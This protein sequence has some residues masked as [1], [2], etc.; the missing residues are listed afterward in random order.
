MRMRNRY[1]HKLILVAWVGTIG[2]DR[3]DRIRKI[4]PIQ[5][6]LE[7]NFW[8]K[9][10]FIIEKTIEKKNFKSFGDFKKYLKSIMSFQNVIINTNTG[11][12]DELIWEKLA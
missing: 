11:R 12:I 9:I 5:F 3:L 10:D 4:D 8:I 1:K 7:G 6:F 2:S